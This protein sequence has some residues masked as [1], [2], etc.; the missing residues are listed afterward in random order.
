MTARRQKALRMARFEARDGGLP[1][2]R[3]WR[4]MAAG[5]EAQL[6]Q[7]TTWRRAWTKTGT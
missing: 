3:R 6:R 2:A 4:E 7:M 1:E 5:L